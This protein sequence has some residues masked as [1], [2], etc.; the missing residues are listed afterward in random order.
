MLVRNPLF[1]VAAILCLGLGTGATTAIFSVVNAVLLR[2]LPYVHAERLIRIFTEFPKEVSRSSPSGFRHFW[3]SPP[4][5]F[6][7]KRDAQSWDRFEGWVNG[8]AN[9]AGRDEPVRATTS[10]VTGGLLEMLGVSPAMGRLLSA[11]DDRPNVAATAV[12]SY[13]L[14]QRAF[15]ADPK[16]LHRDIRLNGAQC[17]V[18][19]I[20]PRGFNFPPGD[21]NPSELWTPLQLDPPIPATA[22]AISFLFWRVLG[23]EPPWR[24]HSP[25]W[26]ATPFTAAKPLHGC[27]TALIPKCTRSCLLVSRMKSFA[28]CALRCWLFSARSLSFS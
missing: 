26:S 1:S 14:W 3:L 8:P 12:L 24:R 21:V 19:G 10:Y 18:V 22:A 5:F 7:I 23:R 2:P 17:T 6:E 20:M 25:K 27:S 13:N 15:G 4:E 28:R 11:D 16:I 9:L